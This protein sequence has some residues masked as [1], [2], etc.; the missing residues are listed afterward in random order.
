MKQEPICKINIVDEEKVKSAGEKM[1]DSKTI[2]NLSD[3]FK[4]LGDSTRLKIVLALAEEE[5][6]VCDLASLINISVS[7]VSHQ[8]RI[9]RNNRLVKYRK[10]GKMVYYSLDDN[11]VV[12][13]VNE[14]KSHVKEIFR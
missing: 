9:L 13:I 10:E 14:A 1:P 2:N 4:S 5:L 12:K 8:L 11:H 6:C 3:T 7:G